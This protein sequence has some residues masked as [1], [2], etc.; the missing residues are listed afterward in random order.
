MTKYSLGAITRF[1]R[2]GRKDARLVSRGF[3]GGE[4]ARRLAPEDERATA[5]Q[6]G[7]SQ[8]GCRPISSGMARYELISKIRETLSVRYTRS[9]VAAA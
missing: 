7:V 1:A 2:R 3:K 5:S 8:P 9:I 4:L 6:I